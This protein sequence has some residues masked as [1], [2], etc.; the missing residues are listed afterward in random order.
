MKAMA[1]ELSRRL[2][3]AL[4]IA[5]TTIFCAGVAIAVYLIWFDGPP[6]AVNLI[7]DLPAEVCSGETYEIVAEIKA[8]ATTIIFSYI[9]TERP[10]GTHVNHPNQ[11]L[12]FPIPHAGES[13]FLQPFIWVVPELSGSDVFTRV[14][15][16]RG[17]DTDE[18]PLIIEEPFTIK[19][20][21]C[22]D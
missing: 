6:I 4:L 20:E 5:L 12:Y 21:S 17:H 7:G 19:K 16:F 3:S 10:N 14:M 15:G 9:S 8:N 1:T 2:S 11:P 22:N 13:T 18:E